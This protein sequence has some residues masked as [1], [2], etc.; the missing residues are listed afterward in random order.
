MT[1]TPKDGNRAFGELVCPEAVEADQGAYSCEAINIKGSCFAGS[2]GCGQPGQDAV[3]IVQKPQGICPSGTFNIKANRRDECLSC[4][5]FGITDQCS[6]TEFYF[7]MVDITT[8]GIVPVQNNMPLTGSIAPSG[9]SGPS[10]ASFYLT[11]DIGGMP[12][13]QL[14]TSM[15]GNQIKSYGGSL[16]YI[17]NFRGQQRPFASPDIIIEVSEISPIS[18]LSHSISLNIT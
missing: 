1:S 4:F 15:L 9:R 10:S 17:I 14:P 13:F 7:Q 11:Q 18:P 16:S 8:L 12:Y 5:C 6:S 3:L 2:S